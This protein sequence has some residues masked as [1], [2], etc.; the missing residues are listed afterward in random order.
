MEQELQIPSCLFGGPPVRDD[1]IKL[2]ESQIG[3]MNIFARP[4]F[5]SVADILPG[6]RF[7]VEEMLV[8]KSIWD[9]KIEETRQAL[10]RRKNPGLHLGLLT[11]SFSVDTTPSPFS[12]PPLRAVVGAPGLAQSHLSRS[13]QNSIKMANPEETA[14][15]STGGSLRRALSASR[16]STD[17]AD[18]ESRRSS[19]TGL[20]NTSQ[21]RRGS[22][23]ASLTAIIVTQTPKSSDK[24]TKECGPSSSAQSSSPSRRKDTLIRSSPKKKLDNSPGEGD[25]AGTRPFTAPSTARRSQGK[26]PSVHDPL[27]SCATERFQLESNSGPAI[28]LF[29]MPH[30]SSRGHSEV[31]LSVTTDGNLGGS[32]AQQWD[33]TK[34]GADNHTSRPDPSHDSNRRSGWWRP[35][36]SRQRT[37][38]LKPGGIETPAPHRETL[39]EPAVPNT[40]S[41]ATSPVSS[42]KASRTGKLKNFFK[43]KPRNSDEHDKQLSSFGSSSHLRTP[44]TSDPGHSVHSD[45]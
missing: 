20:A 13:V 21:S 16:M 19:V 30:P 8:N 34:L 45:D 38:D 29:P 26:S 33:E 44:P 32:R 1:M 37:R 39:L 35:M 31:D 15:H 36:S 7:A 9:N 18:R 5:E 27:L 11:P 28:N 23:D 43:R 12:G 25:R 6:M 2:G 17:G 40:S 14:P 22:G 24:P 10:K 3:F 4:L 42:G 41:N